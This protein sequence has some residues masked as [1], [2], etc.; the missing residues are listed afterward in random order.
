MS[1]IVSAPVNHETQEMCPIFCKEGMCQIHEGEAAHKLGF[2]CLRK[3]A[4]EFNAKL[5]FCRHDLEPLSRF[6]HLVT[7][8]FDLVYC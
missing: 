7:I 2:A 1:E 6:I 8:A 5:P 3:V 4:D